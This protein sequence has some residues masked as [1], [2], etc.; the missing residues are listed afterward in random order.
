MFDTQKEI[1]MERERESRCLIHK[2]IEMERER[3]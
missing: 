2:K 1:E 3:E